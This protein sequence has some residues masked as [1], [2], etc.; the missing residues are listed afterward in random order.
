MM[1]QSS[2]VPLACEFK[3]VEAC[4]HPISDIINSIPCAQ[5]NGYVVHRLLYYGIL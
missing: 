3:L 2:I 5:V 1:F 4:H